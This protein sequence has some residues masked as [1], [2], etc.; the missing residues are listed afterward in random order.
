MRW[1]PGARP[2]FL[3]K[4]QCLTF[5]HLLK[6]PRSAP[7]AGAGRAFLFTHRC[8]VEAAW[9]GA[10]L[11]AGSRQF[12][13]LMMDQGILPS[14]FYALASED[15]GLKANQGTSKSCG[16]RNEPTTISLSVY[17]AALGLHCRAWAFTS[18]GEQRLFFVV[19]GRPQRVDFH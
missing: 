5:L 15:Q 10:Q 2:Y 19:V 8:K 3:Q 17:L 11:Y 4:H 14:V 7:C 16:R 6:V 18:W 13:N 1:Y 12:Q 9:E